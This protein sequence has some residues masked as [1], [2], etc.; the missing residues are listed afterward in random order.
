MTFSPVICERVRHAVGL[1]AI[2]DVAYDAF[3]DMLRTLRA[4]EDPASGLF[5]AFVMAAASAANGRDA[6]LFAPSLPPR[7]G[8][9]DLPELLG[10]GAEAVA[11]AAAELSRLLAAHLAQA[12][13]SSADP[14]DQAACAD[15]AR[16][17]DGI[18]RLLRRGGP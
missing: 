13:E 10:E 2:L 11:D 6:V 5:P 1:T 18:Y 7:R 17:A 9:E 15:A 8:E 16:C 4:H 12:G 14:G 3:E